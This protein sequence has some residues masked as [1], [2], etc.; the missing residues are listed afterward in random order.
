MLTTH[1][2]AENDLL[3]VENG[4]NKTRHQLNPRVWPKTMEAAT[5]SRPTGRLC[6]E[7]WRKIET[8]DAYVIPAIRKVLR[9]VIERNRW[10]TGDLTIVP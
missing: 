3:A 4:G 5:D 2:R 10:K 1:A 8:L 9:R 6:A 7:K